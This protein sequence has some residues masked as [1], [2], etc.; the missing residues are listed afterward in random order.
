MAARP[1]DPGGPA[2]R[3]RRELMGKILAGLFVLAVLL[4]AVDIEARVYAQR[5]LERRIEAKVP[6]ATATV[7]ISSFPFL[8]RLAVSGTVPKIRAQVAHVGSGPFTFDSIV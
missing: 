1:R 5:Q 7:N 4:G 3:R 2:E 8:G 6:G